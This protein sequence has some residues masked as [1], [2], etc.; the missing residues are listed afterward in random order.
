[1][2]TCYSTEERAP[3]ENGGADIVCHWIRIPQLPAAKAVSASLVTGRATVPGW[4]VRQPTRRCLGSSCCE[5]MRRSISSEGAFITCIA[6]NRTARLLP[7]TTDN[8]ALSGVK[9]EGGLV[10]FGATGMCNAYIPRVP[11]VP[12]YE[13]AGF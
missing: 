7:G 12:Q 9:G 4:A 8:V 1:M 5:C 2:P 13:R 3:D 11:L 6:L 10:R